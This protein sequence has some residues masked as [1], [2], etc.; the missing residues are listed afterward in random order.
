M[1][2]RPT[3]LTLLGALLLALPLATASA[4]APAPAGDPLAL[5]NKGVLTAQAKVAPDTP[6]P[7]PDGVVVVKLALTIKDGWH[8]YAN[9]AGNEFAIPTV[10]SIDPKA[11]AKLLGVE[12]PAG[13]LEPQPGGES[14]LV[15]AGKVTATVRLRLHPD[16]AAGKL[17]V[18]LRVRY[19]AC[20]DVSCLAPA[21][22]NVPLEL[23]VP[24]P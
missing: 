12:Y 20:N 10:V 5:G 19:Q 24:A 4:Q 1:M 21:T 23:A 14:A 9:P 6:K 3:P 22:L 8:A 2:R 17:T 18:P 16:V 11:P 13:Q 15:Y 7:K